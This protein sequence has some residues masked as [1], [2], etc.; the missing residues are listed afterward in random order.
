[1][2]AHTRNGAIAV[3]SPSAPSAPSARSAGQASARATGRDAPR[4]GRRPAPRR[5]AAPASSWGK[6][7]DG[8]YAGFCP[9]AVPDGS[10]RGR[11]GWPFICDAHRCAPGAINPVGGAETPCPRARRR[12]AADPIRSCGR[13]G[14]PCRPRRRERGELLPHRFTL[15]PPKRSG[16]FS[17]ALSLGSPRPGVTRRRLSMPPGRSS[18]RP[19]IIGRSAAIQP[20]ARG[21][22]AP[23]GRTARPSRTSRAQSNFSPGSILRPGATS[24]WPT[25]FH[26]ATLQRAAISASSRSSAAICGSGNG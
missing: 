24:S 11:D 13:R 1:M 9:R 12:R 26:G 8:L 23:P 15:A 10:G 2:S 6:G 22:Y 25:T 18:L 7:A 19:T 21:I 17:V 5:A 3:I 16:L 14:L 20:S 4:P